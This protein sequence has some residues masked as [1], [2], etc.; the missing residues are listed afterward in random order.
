MSAARNR[1]IPSTRGA[2]E[3]ALALVAPTLRL[4][5]TL[6]LAVAYALGLLSPAP[7]GAQAVEVY[8]DAPE[9][10]VRLVDDAASEYLVTEKLAAQGRKVRPDDALE[11]AWLEMVFYAIADALTRD[12]IKGRSVR[13]VERLEYQ[14]ETARTDKQI[15]SPPSAK[16]STSLAEKP[17]LPLLLGL[18]IEHGAVQ[19]SV[20]GSA[21]NLST[22]TY[23]L[24]NI[25]ATG[26]TTPDDIWRRIGGSVSIPLSNDKSGANLSQVTEWSVRVQV[27]G[28]RDPTNAAFTRLW[29]TKIAAPSTRRLVELT[30][31]LQA[32][33]SGNPQLT[34]VRDNLLARIKATVGD[35]RADH[36][37]TE[38]DSVARAEIRQV[39]LRALR[40]S[41]YE[42][43]RTNLSARLRAGAATSHPRFEI[44]PA[45]IR[46]VTETLIP[47]LV[48]AQAEENLNIA[49]VS[50]LLDRVKEPAVL[51]LEYTD[52]RD[53]PNRYSEAKL[54]YERH[55]K[56][57][58]VVLNA[59]SS[60]YAHPNAAL[61]QESLRDYSVAFSLEARRANPFRRDANDL[62]DA[63]ISLSA[64]FQHL[65]ESSAGIA[66]VQL[67]GELPIAGGMMLPLS[68]TYANRAEL[69]DE[70]EVRINFGFT[71]DTDKL[72]ALAKAR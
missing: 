56:P 1:G 16:G 29:R 5:A 46:S 19:R 68:M 55:V 61:G 33:L 62:S 71:I 27:L 51:S 2:M 12:A 57:V 7:A 49:E 60:F 20:S 3:T 4:T 32:V 65:E 28:S 15:G 45:T 69:I 59:A 13:D 38:N 21:V 18:A 9:E 64:R 30:G 17:G 37:R 63:L 8:P 44:D 36:S 58:D 39:M 14:A 67:K 70:S 72:F 35:I 6:G 34:G 66:V 22:S 10:L 24:M 47:R 53:T 50:R 40:D 48:Q 11:Q 23:A 26:E 43:V 42:P 52:H 31:A 25:F 54:L 41:I